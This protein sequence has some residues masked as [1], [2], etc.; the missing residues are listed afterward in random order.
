[1]AAKSKS[2]RSNT[3]K[4]LPVLIQ[5]DVPDTS[6]VAAGLEQLRSSLTQAGVSVDLNYSPVR[7]G[8]KSSRRYVLRGVA[9]DSV[10]QAVT[11]KLPVTIYPDLQVDRS[12]TT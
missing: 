11:K 7:I 1:M 2:I 5:V 3:A 8:L 9:S 6:D 4:Q 10:I 12:E